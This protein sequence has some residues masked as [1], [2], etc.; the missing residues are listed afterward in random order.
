MWEMISLFLLFVKENG[1][2]VKEQIERNSGRKGLS[3]GNVILQDSF[4]L[5]CVFLLEGDNLILYFTVL[6]TEC[7]LEP[8]HR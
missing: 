8:C 5:L 1:L 6:L 3:A 7:I 4:P 2:V